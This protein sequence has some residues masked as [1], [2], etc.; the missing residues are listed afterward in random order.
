M[1]TER[2]GHVMRDAGAPFLFA[3]AEGPAFFER[4]GWTAGDVES[5]LKTA[6]KIGRLPL[7]LRMLAM[8]PESSGRQGE[9]PWSG[10][11]LLRKQEKT[12]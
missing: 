6:R 2:I 12:A 9:R 7:V 4:C 3:P 11:C 1:M 5:M 10:V 8:L